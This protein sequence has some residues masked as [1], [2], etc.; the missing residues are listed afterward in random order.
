[1]E[2]LLKQHH[3]DMM[4][5]YEKLLNEIHI[6]TGIDTE[7]R[8]SIGEVL[9][10]RDKRIAELIEMNARL[11]EH[12]QVFYDANTRMRG[13]VDQNIA[14]LLTTVDELQQIIK[15]IG[16]QH[17]AE[18]KKWQNIIQ[19]QK[20]VAKKRAWKPKWNQKLERLKF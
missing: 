2:A 16:I 15:D 4:D 10:E 20:V 6:R 1:M 8:Q 12:N 13:E 19:R 17:E 18:K 5:I 11:V 14:K 3:R 9:R 7:W